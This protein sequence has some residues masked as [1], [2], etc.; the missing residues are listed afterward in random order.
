MAIPKYDEMYAEFLNALSDGQEHKISDIRAEIAEKKGL[1]AEELEERFPEKTNKVF[2]DRVHWS[3]TY[4]KKAGLVGSE[5]VDIAIL[6]MLESSFW[7][8]SS[9]K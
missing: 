6:R 5:N 7:L 2:F 3:K 9:R 4:L 1:T 8:K